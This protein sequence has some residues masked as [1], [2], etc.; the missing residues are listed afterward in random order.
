[1]A[2][3]HQ[4]IGLIGLIGVYKRQ[5]GENVIFFQWGNR[6]LN[7][8]LDDLVCIM[9]GSRILNLGRGSNFPNFVTFYFDELTHLS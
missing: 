8:L 5:T 4:K 7:I 9:M 3:A 1:M 6:I 2:F